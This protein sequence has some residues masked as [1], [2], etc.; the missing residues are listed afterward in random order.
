MLATVERSGAQSEGAD[1][2]LYQY[3]STNLVAV[4]QAIEFYLTLAN[5]GPA[6]GPAR[7]RW[8]TRCPPA[9]RM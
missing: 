5:L 9:S 7:P 8:P 3:A 6:T 4:G 1:F 2:G